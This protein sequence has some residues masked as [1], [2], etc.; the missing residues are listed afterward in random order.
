MTLFAPADQEFQPAAFYA[1]CRRERPVYFDRQQRAWG[2]YRYA[3]VKAV[4]TD[5]ANFSSEYGKWRGEAD[6]RESLISVD[7]PRHRQLRNVIAKAFTPGAIARLAPRIDALARHL[8][9]AIDPDEPFDLVASFAHPLPVMIIAEMLGVPVE[10]RP[11]YK[12]WADALIEGDS[13]LSLRD[14]ERIARS[15]RVMAE[16][17]DYFRGILASRRRRPQDDLITDLLAAEVDGERL[18]EDQILTFCMLLLTAG[19]IT[20]VNLI[21]NA[22]VCLIEHP[23]AIEAMRRDPELI[24]KGLEE[25]LR[26]RSPVQWLV[27]FAS[28]DVILG[29]ERISEGDMVFAFVGSANRDE[30]VFE[31]PERFD[32]TRHPNP[33]LSFGHGV[34]YCIGAPLARLEAKIALKVLFDRLGD[35]RL[36]L[37]PGETLPPLGSSLLHGVSQLPVRARPLA[38]A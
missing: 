1:E 25:V 28:Q 21:A 8:L 24:P 37:P 14:E 36:A 17:D 34:H 15:R 5:Y 9:D 20:T 23:Q 19:H 22:M 2:V 3:D 7:P 33:H 30:A 38:V 6:A 13:S 18:N 16:M 11:R 12:Q 27:R 32:I 4:L 29:G 10:D 35:F 26:Y 31:D